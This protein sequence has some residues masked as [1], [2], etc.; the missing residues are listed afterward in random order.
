[1]AVTINDV[2]KKAGV[3]HT[4]VSWVIHNDPRITQKTKDKVNKVIVDLNYHP[5]YNARSLVKGKTDT[6]AV[7]SSFFS[8][9]FELSI[10]RGIEK[11]M[12]GSKDDYNLSLYSTSNKENDVLREILYGRRADAVIVLSVTPSE[13]IIAAFKE[14]QISLILVENFHEDILSV[15]SDNIK[16][17]EIASDYLFET[18]FKK[19]GIVTED[20]TLSKNPG[21]S[22]IDR[23]E[24]FKNSHKRNGLEVNKDLIFNIKYFTMEEGSR[25]AKKIV[26]EQIDVDAIFCSA[27]DYVALGLI[28]QFKSMGKVIPDDY[29]II[30]FD[31]IDIA[32]LV[33]PPLTTIRQDLNGLGETA[34]KMA[35]DAIS[36][37]D[38]PNL[39]IEFKVKLIKRDSA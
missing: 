2:A 13:Q 1:M 35:V 24:G 33:Y 5:N 32:G 3:S 29:A 7:V 10:L 36:R 18:G 25:I 31:D 4:T 8:S 22:L 6:I 9:Y 37:K 21:L 23:M 15:K 12:A 19:I 34:Y 17:A 38:I 26:E 11:A 28:E 39:L 14:K 27:G 20:L 30:G 16:G